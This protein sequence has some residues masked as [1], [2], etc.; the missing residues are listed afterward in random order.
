M[1]RPDSAFRFK[2]PRHMPGA[3][4]RL[5]ALRDFGYW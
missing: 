4:A 2:R 3:L 1:T 5:A